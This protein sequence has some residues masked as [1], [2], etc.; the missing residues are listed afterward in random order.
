[1]TG[2]L[3]L[4]L[5]DLTFDLFSLIV[6]IFYII[7]I[8]VIVGPSSEVNRDGGL[9]LDQCRALTHVSDASFLITHEVVVIMDFGH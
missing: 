9:L 6:S 1:M 7:I 2:T 3:A 8:G 5:L 4:T